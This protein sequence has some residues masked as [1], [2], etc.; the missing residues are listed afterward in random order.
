MKHIA[1]ITGASSGIGKE[2]V[3]QI[4]GSYRSLDE[5]WLIARREQ[6]LRKLAGRIPDV[7]FRI[8][9]LDLAEK[10]S[11][12]ILE[13]LLQQEKPCIRLLVNSAGLGKNGPVENQSWQDGSTMIDVNCR[14]LT[15]VT[16]ICL[17]FLRKGSRVI[18][19]DSGSAFLPQPGFT[20]YA[21]SKSYVLSFSRALGEELRRRQIS[22]TAVCPGPVDTDFFK[23]GGI[24][25]NSFKKKFLVKPQKVVRKALF[26]AEAGK[27]MSVCSFS[28]WLVQLAG[29]LLPQG[30]IVRITGWLFFDDIVGGL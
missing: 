16:Q 25:L 2:F 1:V 18:Q 6:E 13:Q 4:A 8:L 30:M 17:P 7:S 9:P 3:F 14:A 12:F 19:V 28:I 11:F 10:E 27:A 5:I 22:V 24:R 15:A 20:I 26:D 29:K 23:T 21:A